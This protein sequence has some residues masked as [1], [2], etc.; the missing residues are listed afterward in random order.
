MKS[1]LR[2]FVAFGLLSSVAAFAGKTKA[3]SCVV[4]MSRA[5]VETTADA[6]ALKEQ[7]RAQKAQLKAKKEATKAVEAYFDFVQTRFR[8]PTREEVKSLNLLV[9]DRSKVFGRWG[10]EFQHDVELARESAEYDWK[11]EEEAN[12]EKLN[13]QEISMLTAEA[14]LRERKV[15]R[16]HPE[17][18]IFNADQIA[19]LIESFYQKLAQWVE[20]NKKYPPTFGEFAEFLGMQ[21]AEQLSL[22]KEIFN[23]QYGLF[24]G[25]MESFKRG[26]RFW[27]DMGQFLLA[28]IDLDMWNP[29][30][31]AQLKESLRQSHSL[32][33][34]GYISGQPVPTDIEDALYKM[35]K[36]MASQEK[37]T[38]PIVT[39]PAFGH[40]SGVP[41]RLSDPEAQRYVVPETIFLQDTFGNS[42]SINEAPLPNRALN[43]ETGLDVLLKPSKQLIVVHPQKK[44][45]AKLSDT[46]HPSAVIT[47]GA[48]NKTGYNRGRSAIGARI[49]TIQNELQSTSVL[50]L[51]KLTGRPEF[52]NIPVEA[53]FRPRSIDFVTREVTVKLANDQVITY[54]K[55]FADLNKLY[56]VDGKVYDLPIYALILADDHHPA[57]DRGYFEALD[58]QFLDP[59]TGLKRED[60]RPV[61][62][63]SLVFN[64]HWNGDWISRHT[65]DSPSA[66]ESLGRDPLERDLDLHLKTGLNVQKDFQ[67]KM[68]QT[69]GYVPHVFYMSSNHDQD[70]INRKLSTDKWLQDKV[71]A[72][73]FQKMRSY[74]DQGKNP[75]EAYLLN[76]VGVSYN[77]HVHV[78]KPFDKLGLANLSISHGQ[79]GGIFGRPVNDRIRRAAEGAAAHGHTHAA[80]WAHSV[81]DAGHSTLGFDYARGAF[82][83]TSKAII[84][85]TP[86]GAQVAFYMEGSFFGSQTH[87][88][89]DYEFRP[90]YPQFKPLSLDSQISDR[91]PGGV[92]SVDQY[93]PSRPKWRPQR[94][95]K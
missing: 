3:Q 13:E 26:A 30:I 27:G 84:I 12:N 87:G 20:A 62:I 86:V 32:I 45:T 1:A 35:Q 95:K 76:D 56:G 36:V 4:A 2:I 73:T 47:T 48:L 44:Y 34:A 71:N 40:A 80:G 93:Y 6:Q 75:L 10:E 25:Y 50:K 61:D 21:G 69:R 68:N 23:R 72:A 17:G 74:K 60:G 92:N 66:Q 33:T 46:E 53:R 64:D 51:E 16:T 37:S 94:K 43:P 7:V 15:Y 22:F 19:E 85:V 54:P 8:F 41:E 29:K 77:D 82:N 39:A 42:V 67:M 31:E 52:S 90:G 55:G 79:Y 78:M 91:L 18:S 89:P 88:D 59:I 11:D 5:R 70:R 9:I 83:K 57:H 28:Y 58:R 65:E 63:Y 24:N 14:R 81:Y 38:I 49:S